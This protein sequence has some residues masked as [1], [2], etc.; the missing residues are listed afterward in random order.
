MISGMIDLG[1]KFNEQL[2]SKA[3]L[4]MFSE[5]AFIIW[6]FFNVYD[7]IVYAAMLFM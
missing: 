7:T 6:Y 5:P 2:L 1:R 3:G 4:E